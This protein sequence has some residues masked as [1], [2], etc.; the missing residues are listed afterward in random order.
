[1]NKQELIEELKK[2]IEVTKSIS[3]GEEH[4]KL[5]EKGKRIGLEYGWMFAEKL[6]EPELPIIPPFVADWYEGRKSSIYYHLCTAIES[7]AIKNSNSMSLNKFEFWL[8]DFENENIGKILNLKNGYTIEKETMYYV[9]FVESEDKEKGQSLYKD[10]NFNGDKVVSTHIEP[11]IKRIALEAG[12][13]HFT[14]QEIE[15]IDERYWAF[16]EEVPVK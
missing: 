9:I 1:M 7:A 13:F 16:A 14:K 6:D 10:F 3:K 2:E 11:F 5:Y 15:A 4:V 8:M 12:N